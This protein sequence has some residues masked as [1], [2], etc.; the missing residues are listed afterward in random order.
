MTAVIPGSLAHPHPPLHK[1]IFISY[2]LFHRLKCLPY[3][4]SVEVDGDTKMHLIS[5]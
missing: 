2:L 3:N 1:T 4:A 5:F